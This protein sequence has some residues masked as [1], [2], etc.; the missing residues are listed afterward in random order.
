M[1]FILLYIL[2]VTTLF[3]SCNKEP[4]VAVSQNM[5]SVNRDLRVMQTLHNSQL[6]SSLNFRYTL[7]TEPDYRPNN[8]PTIELIRKLSKRKYQIPL[9]ELQEI[10]KNLSEKY[11]FNAQIY[12][13]TLAPS[14]Q[15]C[16]YE[17]GHRAALREPASPER[18]E[19]IKKS[20]LTLL[21]QGAGDCDAYA[22]MLIA[23]ADE[24]DSPIK[25]EHIAYI[26]KVAGENIGHF[27][28]S[29]K[30]YQINFP[31]GEGVSTEADQ[32]LWLVEN[33]SRSAIYKESLRAFDILK[34]IDRGSL[35]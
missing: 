16:A 25:N 15:L 13:K 29:Y 1:K 7:K 32:A 12:D 31:Q 4:L 10:V 28:E 26:R 34:S 9:V 24:L 5:A 18:N 14:M 17:V 33:Y 35:D 21:A 8:A 19:I 23:V 3:S 27:N 30:D 6:S 22:E 11:N 2:M 20:L